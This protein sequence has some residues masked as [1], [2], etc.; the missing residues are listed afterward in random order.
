MGLPRRIAGVADETTSDPVDVTPP[1]PPSALA[2]TVK[3]AR[4]RGAQ[5]R[6]KPRPKQPKRSRSLW[7]RS[8]PIIP[9]RRR[10]VIK[11]TILPPKSRKANSSSASRVGIATKPTSSLWHRSRAWFAAEA[12]PT[13][14]ICGSRSRAR[15]DA[16]SATSS[17]VPLCRTHHRDNHRFGDEQAWWGKTGHRSSRDVT[18]ALDLTRGIE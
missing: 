5:E 10:R 8:S 12:P 15:W 7:R 2:V 3:P 9:C 18:A 4:R 6:P 14:T 13:P 11:P 17:R 16:R 1:E